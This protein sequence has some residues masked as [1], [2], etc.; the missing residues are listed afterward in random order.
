M[1]TTFQALTTQ[2][3]P[4]SGAWIDVSGITGDFILK[5]RVHALTQGNNCQFLIEESPDGTTVVETGLGLSIGGGTWPPAEGLCV[6]FRRRDLG[7]LS[8]F[9]VTGGKARLRLDQID[10]GQVQYESWLET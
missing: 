7:N 5:I 10:G 6:S 8:K 4:F 9:G 2:T 3:A 1:R